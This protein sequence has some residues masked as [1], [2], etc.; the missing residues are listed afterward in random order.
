MFLKKEEPETETETEET[1]KAKTKILA[2]TSKGSQETF[3][4]TSLLETLIHLLVA[5]LMAQL[6]VAFQQTTLTISTKA[7]LK[8]LTKTL[9]DFLNK[10]LEEPDVLV[11]GEIKAKI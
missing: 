7:S 8:L 6:L 9:K 2:V 11:E 4:Q 5:G 10:I 3:L 1:T